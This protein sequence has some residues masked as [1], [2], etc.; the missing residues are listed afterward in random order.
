[1]F[2]ILK[3]LKKILGF[4]Q[5]KPEPEPEPK[6]KFIGSGLIMRHH[7]RV[8]VLD[9]G[10]VEIIFKGKEYVFEKQFHEEHAKNTFQLFIVENIIVL[11]SD[12]MFVSFVFENDKIS[13]IGYKTYQELNNKLFSKENII[14]FSFGRMILAF[15]QAE[16]KMFSMRNY[17]IRHGIDGGIL[18][19]V[20]GTPYV[21]CCIHPINSELIV[22]SINLIT[23]QQNTV[24]TLTETDK[25][26]SFETRDGSLFIKT[27]DKLMVSSTEKVSSTETAV[28]PLKIHESQ[29]SF[30][31]SIIVSN[32]PL[33]VSCDFKIVALII[34]GHP[35]EVLVNQH[36]YDVDIFFKGT[37]YTFKRPFGDDH[38]TD[39]L[40]LF[41]YDNLIV[42]LSESKSSGRKF[43]LFMYEGDVFT[44]IEFSNRK[45]SAFRCFVKQD[46]IVLCAR[47]KALSLI[48]EF[49]NFTMRYYSILHR[50][51]GGILIV[52][53]DIPYL[54]VCVNPVDS[55]MNLKVVSINLLTKEQKKVL[56][57]TP[58][59]HYMA[60]AQKDGHLYL[61]TTSS[62]KFLD[63]NLNQRRTL[64]DP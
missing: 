57:M 14:V 10:S 23:G 17:P 12:R 33:V 40:Q 24:L 28:D 9:N 50:I 38:S 20:E 61:D 5:P 21:V 22:V 59:D 55:E 35:V 49:G 7:V 32:K 6:L 8:N 37:K 4:E 16:N 64:V 53:E 43:A 18:T 31:P 45:G 48:Q 42:L 47:D 58:Y 56:E 19:F 29:E 41:S 36:H 26:G 15:T 13:K 25:F 62:I 52:V 60:F 27:F 11:V 39:K 1:M 46:L 30:L 2:A 34:L 51:D 54:V 44:K 63:R 3:H